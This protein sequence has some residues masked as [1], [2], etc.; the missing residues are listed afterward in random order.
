VVLCV[1]RGVG[2]GGAALRPHAPP[3][4]P[5]QQ[6][7]REYPV[8]LMPARACQSPAWAWSC[9]LLPRC[10]IPA[11]PHPTATFLWWLHMYF[12]LPILCCRCVL[13]QVHSNRALLA[14]PWLRV[15][16]VKN[17]LESMQGRLLRAAPAFAAAAPAPVAMPPTLPC[18]LASAL[19][20]SLRG[21][22]SHIDKPRGRQST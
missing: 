4:Q 1:C 17:N 12:P 7:L 3:A 22:Q 2:R 8:C 10:T 5:C 9:P 19:P 14:V 20:A 16:D 21:R 18:A 13:P 11:N 6:R 15:P